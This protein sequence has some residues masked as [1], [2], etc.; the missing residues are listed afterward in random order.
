ML[1]FI[2]EKLEEKIGKFISDSLEIKIITAFLKRSGLEFLNKVSHKEVSVICGIDFFITEPEAL[3]YLESKNYKINIFYEPHKTFHPKCIYIKTT[4]DEYLVVGSSNIT[5]GGLNKNYEASV[6]ISKCVFN[7]DVF[8]IFNNYFTK[9]S[10]SKY[11][12]GLH[13]PKFEKYTNDYNK[14]KNIKDNFDKEM[15]ELYN[16][17]EKPFNDIKEINIDDWINHDVFGLGSVFEKNENSIDVYFIEHG[18]KKIEINNKLEKINT[19]NS[20]YIDKYFEVNNIEKLN[21]VIEEYKLKGKESLKERDSFYE[22]WKPYFMKKMS[23]TDIYNFFYE[24]SKIWTLMKL[25]KIY[26]SKDADVFNKYMEILNDNNISILKRFDIVCNS[27]K[28]KQIIK[29][30][31]DGI[32]SIILSF[33]YPK[34]CI[35]YNTASNELLKYFNIRIKYSINKRL[36]YKYLQYS[37]FGRW[38]KE[39]YNFR[40]FVDVDNFI[41]FVKVNYLN[42]PNK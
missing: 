11:C 15:E 25:K 4:S 38:L 36:T 8:E 37:F 31:K 32:T 41:G 42:R 30:I 18:L 28:N 22:K 10:E 6:L 19:F 2:H 27:K 33:L 39:N 3:K 24:S 40:D 1:E 21:Q 16:K 17:N 29:G 34:E 23:S 7:K 5:F 14:Y 20:K 35:V 9:L 12:I 26:I 13:H